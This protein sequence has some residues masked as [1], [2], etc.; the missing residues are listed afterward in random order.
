L[1]ILQS[2]LEWLRKTSGR[3]KL[4]DAMRIAPQPKTAVALILL[5]AVPTTKMGLNSANPGLAFAANSAPD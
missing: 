5:G 4:V 2:F 1:T 3:S